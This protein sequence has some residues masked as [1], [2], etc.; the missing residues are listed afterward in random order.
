MTEAKMLKVKDLAARDRARTH[1]LRDGEGNIHPTEFPP[2][3]YKDLSASLALPLVGN[4]G[5]EVL[6]LDGKPMKPARHRAAESIMLESDQTIARYSELTIDALV[7][8]ARILP[9]GDTLSRKDGK[10]TLINFILEGGL[11][12]DIGSVSVG[13][14]WI[15]GP[16]AAA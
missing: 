5:F 12:A 6:G 7:E 8:R 16:Q 1:D 11:R 3:A 10:E 13:G 2:K 15:D 4:P 14:K 9:G